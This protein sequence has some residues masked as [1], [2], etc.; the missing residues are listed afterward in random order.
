MKSADGEESYPGNVEVSVEYVLTNNNE[1]K[2]NY[3]GT[4]DKRTPLSLTNHTYFNLN[5]FKSDALDHNVQ[6]LSNAYLTPDDVGMHDGKLTKVNGATDFNQLKPLR[7]AFKALP[8]GFEHFY[9]FDNT[10]KS[11]DKIAYVE[12]P[13]SGRSMEVFTTEPSTLFY[14]GRY[15]SDKLARE[16]GTQ[17]GQFRAF[18]IETSKYPNGPNIPNSPRTILNPGELYSETTVY[19]FSW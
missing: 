1:L 3:Q 18:C 17:F 13:T 5:G 7:S 9:V 6:L 15:T 2:I 12:E 8:Q 4:T 16:D 11:L 10:D 14:T 19:K